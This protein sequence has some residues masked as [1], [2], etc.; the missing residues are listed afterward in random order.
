MKYSNG[1]EARVGDIAGTYAGAR[2][3]LKEEMENGFWKA[4]D[5]APGD[6][7]D[8]IIAPPFDDM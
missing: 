5:L 3:R 7:L 2:Y 4:I 8:V 6:E 1:V